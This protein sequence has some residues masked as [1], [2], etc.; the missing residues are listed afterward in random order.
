MI[1]HCSSKYGDDSSPLIQ[2]DELDLNEQVHLDMVMTSRAKIK[3]L[4]E[5]KRED[6]FSP[7]EIE[8]LAEQKALL[9]LLVQNCDHRVFRDEGGFSFYER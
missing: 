5:T 7:K 2:I 6:E 8:L 1:G 9:K 4:N 3:I